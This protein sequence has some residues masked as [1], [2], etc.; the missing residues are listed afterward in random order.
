[1]TIT[2]FHCA[3]IHLMSAVSSAKK[4]MISWS[5]SLMASLCRARN[6]GDEAFFPR[7][8]VIRNSSRRFIC[9]F[10]EKRRTIC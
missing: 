7:F 6:S 5:T 2:E 1:M 4:A 8:L 9:S 3:V 10:T